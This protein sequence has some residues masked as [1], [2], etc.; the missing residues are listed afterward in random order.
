MNFFKAYAKL[1]S[2]LPT[3]RNLVLFE[4]FSESY[5]KAEDCDRERSQCGTV[6][7]A[8]AEHSQALEKLSASFLADAQYF[9]QF[10]DHSWHWP[11]LTS[12]AMTSTLLTANG[13][14]D[15]IQKMLRRA[16]TVAKQM[17][18]LRVMEIWNGREGEAMVF[19]YESPRNGGIATVLC[20]GTWPLLPSE[21]VRKLWTEV[22][23]LQH[24][25]VDFDSQLVDAGGISS[26]AAAMAVLGLVNQV[27]R[28]I[29]Q[30]QIFFETLARNGIK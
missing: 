2:S 6:S 25:H 5:A 7:K 27:I 16:S 11:N 20:R 19:R 13:C 1:F 18:I 23:E 22:A 24:C 4:N 17:P 28:P 26:H 9:F 21:K 3:V 14:N 29:S 12:F 10:T 15:K 30:Q 8:V